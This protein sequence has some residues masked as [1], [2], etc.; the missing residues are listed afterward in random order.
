MAEELEQQTIRELDAAHAEAKLAYRARNA[1]AYMGFFSPE[2][3]YTQVNGKTIGREQLARDVQSQFARVRAM[4][5]SY[6]RQSLIVDKATAVEYLV[7]DAWAETVAFF[8]LRRRWHVV[9][10]G[11]YEWTRTRG[12]WKIRKVH[13]LEEVVK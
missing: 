10:R 13:V 2:L 6:E 1:A 11:R 12:G 4:D 8:V 3:E 9:R 7:Q 5:T